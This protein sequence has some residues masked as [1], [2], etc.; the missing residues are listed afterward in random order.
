EPTIDDYA[1][2]VVDLLD[3]LHVHEAVVAGLS[4]GGYVALG[5]VRCAAR[6]VHA[7]VLADTKAEPDTPDAAAGR[8]R[9]AQLA[10]DRGGGAVADELVPRLLGETT[11]RDRPEVV[12][13]VDELARSNSVDGVAGA[14]GAL[15][16]RPDSTPLLSSIHVPALVIVG[17]EDA[18]TPPP[19][20]EAMH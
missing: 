17:K 2:D 4:M 8:T 19:A 3:A 6:Y 14:L 20:A 10:R 15:K 11:R 16:S 5:I 18:I 12:A 7:L 13:A 1:G 9:M